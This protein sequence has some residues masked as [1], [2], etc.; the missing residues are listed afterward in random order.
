[1]DKLPSIDG[2]VPARSFFLTP[3]ETLEHLPSDTL[4]LQ[5]TA[6]VSSSQ[7]ESG[8][9]MAYKKAATPAKAPAPAPDVP[10]QPP[11]DVS[12]QLWELAKS[13]KALV[14]R[15]SAQESEEDI[16]QGFS[17]AQV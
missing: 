4:H 9:E 13:T 17:K 16:E 10:R 6:K 15:L 3:Y 8:S 1:M 11:E 14:E 12:A 5:S 7:G 2:S